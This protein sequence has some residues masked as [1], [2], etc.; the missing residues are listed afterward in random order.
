MKRRK[1]AEKCTELLELKSK[2][3][4]VD[5]QIEKVHRIE[6]DLENLAEQIQRLTEGRIDEQMIKYRSR[7]RFNPEINAED[8][9]YT[10]KEKKRNNDSLTMFKKSQMKLKKSPKHRKLFK[11]CFNKNNM[12]LGNLVNTTEKIF[13]SK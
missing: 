2:K 4:L 10:G 5:G 12:A 6:E 9:N 1:C 7:L 8:V 11:S 13:R 3:V